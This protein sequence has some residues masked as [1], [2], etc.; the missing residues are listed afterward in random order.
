MTPALAR[1]YAKLCDIRDFDDPDVL[2]AIRATRAR[3]RSAH[4]HRAEGV[5]VRDGRSCSSRTSGASTTAPR[6]CRWA[7]GTSAILYWLAD[8]V[9]RVVA[10]D[11][12]GEGAFAG[13][14]AELLDARGPRRPRALA[15]PGGPPGGALDGRPPSS[16]FPTPSFDAVF[17]LSSI[18]HFGGAGGHRRAR[19]GDRPGAP[20]RGP[21]VR[22]HGV[23]RPA[24]PA[25]QRAGRTPRC[26]WPRSAASVAGRPCVAG[27]RWAT[28]SPRASCGRDRRA[29]AGCGCSSRSISRFRPSPGTTA[30]NT[31]YPT[32]VVQISLSLFT[33]VCLALEKP[34][35]AAIIG[36]VWRRYRFL[37][38][39]MVRRELR[40]K[41]KGSA[42]GVA[43]VPRQPRG[44]HGRIRARVL[45]A[46]Q[47]GG[48]RALPAV[49]DL[50]A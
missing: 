1:Q 3:A 8:R 49:P 14:E 9:G 32:I 11:I 15:L 46:A 48:H 47:G 43:L 36:T 40:Q 23:P 27:L 7:P 16:T 21:R 26:G 25:D 50:R 31:T 33:S 17:T 39:Q 22:G 45:G 44:A 24:P 5:G 28:P 35:P 34:G 41:Y 12:Y 20:A 19:L 38:E 30:G 29:R 6:S 2:A 37:F 10:T 42:L 4:A 18:E 13:R